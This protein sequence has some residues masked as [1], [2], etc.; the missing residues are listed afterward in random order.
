[1][2]IANVSGTFSQ[3]TSWQNLVGETI[4]RGTRVGLD[5]KI[6]CY[7]C[8]KFYSRRNL[9]RHNRQYCAN[10]P[11]FIR[12]LYKC[13]LCNYISPYSFNVNTHIRRKHLGK[14]ATWIVVNDSTQKNNQSYS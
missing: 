3:S 14:N 2:E 5:G 1:M 7:N 8:K 4:R 12:K 11:N 9:A 13:T 10:N 6:R